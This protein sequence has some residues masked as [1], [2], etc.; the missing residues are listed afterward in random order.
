MVANKI[1]REIVIEAPVER[2]WSA[3]TEPEHLGQWFGVQAPSEVDL[4]QGGS[5]IFDHGEHGRFPASIVRY[6]PQAAFAYR[7]ASDFPGQWP[8]TGNSTLVEFTLVAEGD[9]TRLRVV[10]T[11]FADLALP[12]DKRWSSFQDNTAGWREELGKLRKYAEQLTV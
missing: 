6:E 9:G 2:V 8:D 12:E 7:W 1:E 3:L 11:G 4:R 10:E 5:M